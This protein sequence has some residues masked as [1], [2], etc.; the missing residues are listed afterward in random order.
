MRNTGPTDNGGD[1]T[2]FVVDLSDPGGPSGRFKFSVA[3]RLGVPSSAELEQMIRRLTDRFRN[4]RGV[5][6]QLR[7]LEQLH[8]PGSDRRVVFLR[9]PDL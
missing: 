2:L 8:P 5:V 1:D 6:E 4:D 3:S 9:P 7:E